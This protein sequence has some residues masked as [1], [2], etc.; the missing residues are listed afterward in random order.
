MSGTNAKTTQM[1]ADGIDNAQSTSICIGVS[2]L[3]SVQYHATLGLQ[4]PDESWNVT[5][6]AFISSMPAGQAFEIGEVQL[7]LNGD[8]LPLTPPDQTLS[9]QPLQAGFFAN[10]ISQTLEA[11]LTNEGGS[12]SVCIR[13]TMNSSW[14]IGAVDLELLDPPI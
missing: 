10:L 5:M 11:R 6:H 4:N 3:L 12:T 9:N 8:W 2:R 13:G 7:F 1:Q 14:T